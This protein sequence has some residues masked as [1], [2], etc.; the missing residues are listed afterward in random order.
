MIF[1]KLV[2][3]Q[4]R[5]FGQFWSE[6]IRDYPKTADASPLLDASDVESQRLVVLDLPPLRR[7]MSFSENDQ[8]VAQLQDTRLHVNWRRTK[9]EDQYPRYQEVLSRFEHLWSEFSAF[10]AREN[11]GPLSILRY[12]LS[13]FNHIEMGKDVA[14]LIEENIKFF[15]FLPLRD[16]YPSTQDSVTAAWRFGMPVRRERRQLR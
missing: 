2:G 3:I 5:H 14:R 4:S 11:V 1:Q 15:Q 8:Y 6:Q 12:E 10:V 9:P 13:Y 16:S 7:M